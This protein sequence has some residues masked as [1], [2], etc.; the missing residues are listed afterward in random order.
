MIHVR[1]TGL[2]TDSFVAVHQIGST[3]EEEN[4]DGLESD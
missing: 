2:H 3:V 1:Y 4:Q